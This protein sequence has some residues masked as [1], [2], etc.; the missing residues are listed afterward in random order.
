MKTAIITGSTNPVGNIIFEKYKNQY[1]WLVVSRSNGFDLLTQ[2]SCDRVVE[3]AK[4]AD[5]FFNIACIVHSQSE[6][7]IRVFNTWKKNANFDIK[8][9]ISFG[10]LATDFSVN[11]LQLLRGFQSEYVS[12][13][14]LLEKAHK[15][16]CYDH[17]TNNWHNMPQSILI[18]FGNLLEASNN[19]PFTDSEQLIEAVDYVLNSQSYISDLSVRW[20]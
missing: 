16:L 5:V 18:K 2:E 12:T 7:A 20:N 10:T 13:K 15:E 9:I 3:L 11:D 1:N 17:L 14:L 19:E 6:L 8:K 4:D